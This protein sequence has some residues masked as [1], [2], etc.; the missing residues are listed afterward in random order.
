MERSKV[1]RMTAQQIRAAVAKREEKPFQLV[2]PCEHGHYLCA[3]VE[4]GACH[5]EL[6][7]AFEQLEGR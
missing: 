1:E 6:L 4:G 2:E 7:G 5:D 3:M